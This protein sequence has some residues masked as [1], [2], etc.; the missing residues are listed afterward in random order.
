MMEIFK[1]IFSNFWVFADQKST[2]TILRL[3]SYQGP[4]D[5]QM[6]VTKLNHLVLN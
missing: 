3:G 1:M 5:K 4:E 6:Q 2:A